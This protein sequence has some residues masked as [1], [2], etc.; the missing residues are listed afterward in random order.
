MGLQ[1]Y[2]PELPKGTNLE[3][4]TVLITGGTN[5]IGFEAARQFLT[6]KVPRIIITARNASRGAESVRAL[7]ADPEV[8]TTPTQSLMSLTWTLT[9]TSR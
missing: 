1:P 6:F 4:S 2:I 7:R 9:I 8:S 3:G 5:G